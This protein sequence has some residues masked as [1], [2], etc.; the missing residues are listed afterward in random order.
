M[1]SYQTGLAKYARM[2]GAVSKSWE[3][4]L[5]ACPICKPMDG[6]TIPID[7]LF[8]FPNGAEV[9]RPSVHPRDRCGVIYN[10]PE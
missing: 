8:V 2:T 3:S 1:N 7:E 10:Y 9:D 6:V 5:G 4:L